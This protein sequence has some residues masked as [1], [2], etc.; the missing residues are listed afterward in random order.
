MNNDIE[1]E[2]VPSALFN[3]YGIK[4]DNSC[5]YLHSVYH[6]GID[7]V[8]NVLN[9]P[10]EIIN[11]VNPYDQLIKHDEKMIKEIVNQYEYD[12]DYEFVINTIDDIKDEDLREDIKELYESIDENTKQKEIMNNQFKIY[13]T[14]II[15]DIRQKILNISKQGIHHLIIKDSI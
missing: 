14:Q 8:K 6:G 10:E 11:Y 9:G 2:C 15:K 7:Y 3:T 1:Y 4:K 12:T 5:E 13:N